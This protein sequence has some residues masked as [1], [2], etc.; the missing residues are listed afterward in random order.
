MTS[1]QYRQLVQNCRRVRVRTLIDGQL[2]GKLLRAAARD[3]RQRT[4]AQSALE[5]VSAPGWI[6]MSW[7][8]SVKGGTVTVGAGTTAI[9]EQIQR[10]RERL[11]RELRRRL[12][13]VRRVRVRWPVKDGE[14][15]GQRGP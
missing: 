4:Q 14:N 7:V 11:A 9:G 8:E 10:E 15:A 5:G 6:G 13:G 2:E 3:I 1:E 12:A